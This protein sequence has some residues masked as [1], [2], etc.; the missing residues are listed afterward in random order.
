MQT[1]GQFSIAGELFRYA[2][3]ETSDR[4]VHVQVLRD[5]DG[6]RKA[7]LLYPHTNALLDLC[8]FVRDRL[9]LALTQTRFEDLPGSKETIPADAQ[10]KA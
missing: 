1:H 10:V 4:P 3:K 6:L 2:L 9:N 7:V 8:G 5:S